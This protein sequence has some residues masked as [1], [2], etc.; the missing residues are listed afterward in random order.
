MTQEE[1]QQMD[2]L[3]RSIQ[4]EKDPRGF[5]ELEKQLNDLLDRTHRRIDSKKAE[6]R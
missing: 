2:R 6:Q 4:N 1:R 5:T 3:C